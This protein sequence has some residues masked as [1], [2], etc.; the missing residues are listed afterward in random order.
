MKHQHKVKLARKMRTP[1]EISKTHTDAEGKRTHEGIF[2]T[3]AWEARKAGIAGRVARKQT[4]AHERAVTRRASAGP[5]Q[6]SKFR[7][8]LAEMRAQRISRRA[9]RRAAY[10]SKHPATTV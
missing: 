3:A 8:R 6:P 1:D 10:A 9:G 4:L 7:L 2:T 5:R